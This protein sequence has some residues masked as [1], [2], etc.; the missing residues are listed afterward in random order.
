MSVFDLEAPRLGL[1]EM[2]SAC[3]IALRGLPWQR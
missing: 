2:N 3:G 1:Q